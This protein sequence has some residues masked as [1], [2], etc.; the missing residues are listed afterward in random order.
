MAVSYLFYTQRIYHN[1]QLVLMFHTFNSVGPSNSVCLNKDISCTVKCILFAHFL[2]NSDSL[3]TLS[4]SL[5]GH[6]NNA[7]FT[8]ASWVF[9][10]LSALFIDVDDGMKLTLT[11]CV[12]DTKGRRVFG[13]TAA[14]GWVG[15]QEAGGIGK[16]NLLRFRE[17]TCALIRTAS[18]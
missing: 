18:T 1:S 12:D 8:G 5:Q 2:F 14:C 11:R 13:G 9:I 7:C 4:D 3:G 17:D 10:S 16:Q 15:P 6:G